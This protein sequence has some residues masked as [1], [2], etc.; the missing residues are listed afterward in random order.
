MTDE[1]TTGTT[2]V[3]PVTDP[4]YP[5]VVKGDHVPDLFEAVVIGPTDFLVI[6]LRTGLS[7]AEFDAFRDSLLEHMPLAVSGRVLVIEAEQLGVI[8]GARE[9]AV[10]G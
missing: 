9:D 4:T 7:L 10:P 1:Q 2:D 8:R 6:K 5:G 3:P